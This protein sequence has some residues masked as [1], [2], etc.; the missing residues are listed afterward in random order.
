[1]KPSQAYALP[2]ESSDFRYFIRTKSGGTSIYHPEGFNVSLRGSGSVRIRTVLPPD[3]GRTA[4]EGT[5][6]MQERINVSPHDLLWIRLPLPAGR[7]DLYGNLYT[8]DGLA[9]SEARFRTVRQKLSAEVVTALK[10]AEGVAFAR[11]PFEV[12][13]LLSSPC[14]LYAMGVLAARTFLVN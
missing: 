2:V 5:L 6:V 10:G 9:Q 7:V 3:Q 11:S 4:L 12:V 8:T 1:V 13:P 14:D